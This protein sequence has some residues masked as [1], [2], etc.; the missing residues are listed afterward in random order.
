M[1]P[2]PFI[3]AAARRHY[4]LVC[5]AIFLLFTTTST[6]TLLSVVLSNLRYGQADIG[7]ILAAPIAPVLVSLLLAGRVVE[8]IGAL[9]T[10]LVGAGLTVAGFVAFEVGI[11]S[12]AGAIV[13]RSV[14]GLGFGL[15]FSASTIFVRNLLTGPST[16]YFFGIFSA[17][18]PLPNAF[19]PSLGE[20]YLR[21]FGSDHFF[22]WLSIPAIIGAC[23]LMVLVSFSRHRRSSCEIY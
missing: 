1:T 19:A 11:S 21:R 13:C 15:L 3:D 22:L 6:L 4:I 5:A 14:I 2:P 23:V 12:L 8:R 9:P 16:T 20:W 18:V 10:M 7:Q 17:L